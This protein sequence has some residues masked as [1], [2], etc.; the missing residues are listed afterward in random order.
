MDCDNAFEIEATI[1]EKEEEKNEKFICPKCQSRNV[2][3]DFLPFNFFKNVFKGE[4]KAGGCCSGGN[5]CGTGCKPNKKE[6]DCC[7]NNNKDACCG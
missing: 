1:Q 6:V 4:S 3:Y 7:G 5:S 2:R